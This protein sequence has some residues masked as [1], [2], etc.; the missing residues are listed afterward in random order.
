M[1]GANGC[2]GLQRLNYL[3]A[4]FAGTEEAM[5]QGLTILGQVLREFFADEQKRDPEV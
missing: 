1:A 3:R 2:L 4:T 5:E